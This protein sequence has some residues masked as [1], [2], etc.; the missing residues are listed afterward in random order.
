MSH[1]EREHKVG[2][3]PAEPRL[4]PVGRLVRPVVQA[5]FVGFVV[6][7]FVRPAGAGL[8]SGRS[9]ALGRQGLD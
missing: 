1:R 5:G 9:S 8:Q 7:G 3:V 2:R 6:D 4:V